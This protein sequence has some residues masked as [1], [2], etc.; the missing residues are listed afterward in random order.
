[1]RS[2][3]GRSWWAKWATFVGAAVV[4]IG[5]QG[6]TSTVFAGFELP[7][8]ERITNLPPIP[9]S[10][11]QKEAYEI[12]DPVIG[13]NFDVKNFWM[14]ADLRVRPEMR[15]NTC[16]GQTSAG[17]ACNGFNTK[18]TRAGS[19]GNTGNK[20]NDFYVQQWVRLGIGYDLS[21]DVNFYME[22]IDSATWGGNG[23]Q[24]N[25]GNGG[26]PLNHNCSSTATGACRLGVRAAYVLVRNFAGVQGLSMKAGRQYLIFGNHSLFGHFDWA[27]TGYSHDG[28]MFA[29]QT[30]NFDSY[31]GWF[32]NSESD[33]PQAAAV[34]S[35]G[36]D[37]AGNAANTGDA[38]RDADMIVFY[39]QIKS[40]PGFIIEPYYVYYKNNYSSTD[41]AGGGVGTP[42]HSNQTRHMVGGRIEMRKGNW[43]A[44]TENAWQFGQM[45]QNAG[46]AGAGGCAGQEKCLH[47]NAWASRSWIGYTVYEHKWK[48]RLAFNFDYASGDGRNYCSAS[49]AVG[50]CKSANTFENFFPTN[51]IH[52]GYMDILAWKNT[53]SPSANLQFRPSG[54]DHIEIWYTNINLS[55]SRDCWYRAAQACYVNSGVATNKTHVGDELDLT[56]TR[57]FADGKIAFQATYG[58]LFTGGYLTQTLNSQVNQHWAYAQIWMNF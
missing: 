53:F 9:R 39:N 57:M 51:H 21:P 30:K 38:N 16:F 6:G 1:M 8:G 55:S 17:L 20:G 13:R 19:P 44:I 46:A 28:V 47:I 27:N 23:T 18:G 35:G 49:A 5:L 29:Y 7:P 48:P 43:D 26:D 11:P 3:D 37:I 50:S 2:I 24:V 15:T 36:A 42:K 56:W 22:I 45:G 4:A 40:V 31:L 41:F 12:Y 52:M 54:R 32:R 10:I 14:R 34:G 25:A 58:T 33:L